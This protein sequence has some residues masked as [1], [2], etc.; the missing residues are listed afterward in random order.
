MSYTEIVYYDGKKYTAFH[1]DDWGR[2]FVKEVR[3]DKIIGFASDPKGDKIIP[4]DP[5]TVSIDTLDNKHPTVLTREEGIRLA[6]YTSRYPYYPKSDDEAWVLSTNKSSDGTKSYKLGHVVGINRETNEVTIQPL[7]HHYQSYVTTIVDFSDI[8]PDVPWRKK[9][10]PQVDFAEYRATHNPFARK[11][12]YNTKWGN[13]EQ[14]NRLYKWYSRLADHQKDLVRTARKNFWAYGTAW[15]PG[16]PTLI[17][18]GQ[19]AFLIPAPVIP[20][21][22]ENHPPSTTLKF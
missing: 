19:R 20:T 11:I 10:F 18:D 21:P 15:A 17:P 3:D 2:V 7:D 9:G 12:N 6:T 4:V 5:I 8:K 14:H 13:K 1:H 16:A 22:V